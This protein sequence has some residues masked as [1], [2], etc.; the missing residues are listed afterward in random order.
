MSEKACAGEN[1]LISPECWCFEQK[2]GNLS[3]NQ[4]RTSFQAQ[5]R[6]LRRFN[7]TEGIRWMGAADEQC[8]GLAQQI[9]VECVGGCRIICG[10]TLPLCAIHT[11]AAPI[12]RNAAA[13]DSD[14]TTMAST[15]NAISFSSS[16][17]SSSVRS[18][19]TRP[20]TFKSRLA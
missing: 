12:F 10:T 17:I 7:Q 13:S 19:I 14:T 9:L 15:D 4:Q 11:F 5:I 18:V 16:A 8:E 3:G 2:I 1:V 6:R 20:D